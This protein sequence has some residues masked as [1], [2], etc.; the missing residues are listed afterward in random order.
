M[1]PPP[2]GW[3]YFDSGAG[4]ESVSKESRSWKW[5]VSDLRI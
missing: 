5:E 2:W 4:E 1:G 3:R